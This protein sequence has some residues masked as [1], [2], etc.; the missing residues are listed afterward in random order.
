MAAMVADPCQQIKA[1]EAAAEAGAFMAAEQA[2]SITCRSQT[3]F[4]AEA[5]E[6]HHHSA[7]CDLHQAALM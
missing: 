2:V 6:A 5:E 4:T 3:L 1:Q 7:F